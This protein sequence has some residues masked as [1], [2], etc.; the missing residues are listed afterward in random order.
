MMKKTLILLTLTSLFVLFGGMLG[1]SANAASDEELEKLRNSGQDYEVELTYEQVVERTV[2][3]TG[4]SVDEVKREIA[5]STPKTLGYNSKAMA[6]SCG[7]YEVS[8]TLSIGKSYKP[9]LIVIPRTCRYGSAGWIETAIKPHLIGMKAD[10]KK[11]EG[12]IEVRLNNANFS[13]V[14]NGN[15]Y[16][17]GTVSHGGTTG[18]STIWTTTYTVSTSSSHYASWYS[19]VKY[20]QVFN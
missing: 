4:K 3:L 7:W 8:T 14:I 17:H 1:K 6:S 9:T 12:Q 10:G 2:E 16:N 18:I 20:R 19:G 13:Y 11:F 15:W 5:L